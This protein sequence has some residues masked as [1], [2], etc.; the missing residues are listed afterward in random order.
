MTKLKR[1]YVASSWKNILHP[2]IVHAL[3]AMSRDHV[4]YDFRHPPDG[5]TDF[6]WSQIDGG[7][8]SWTPHQA[9]MA[10]DHPLAM[11]GYN[12]D[13][14]AL[15]ECDVCVL[16]LPAGRS[17]SWEL[18]YAMGQGKRG[19]VVQLDR[20]EPELMFREATICTSMDELFDAF[21]FAMNES[22]MARD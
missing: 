11:A 13:I 6:R 7:W 18:G 15:R 16:V 17:A 22:R 19:I 4:V 12:S 14:R 10:L 2:G 21:G 9:R 20:E 5:P 1:I 3:R 8:R